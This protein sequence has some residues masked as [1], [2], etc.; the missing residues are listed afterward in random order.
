MLIRTFGVVAACLLSGAALAQDM[1]L[2]V[3]LMGPLG[4]KTSRKGDRVFGRVLDPVA[5]KGDTVEGTVNEVR[6]GGKLRGSAVLHFSFETLQHAG[7]AIP[8][9]T[10]LK[11]FQNSQGQADVDEEGRV[12]RQGGGAA[13]KAAAGTAAGGLIGGLAGGWKGAAIGA[14]AGAAASIAVIE[15]TSDAPEI[16]FNPGSVVTIGAKTRGGPALTALG[17]APAAP[18]AAA[19]AP[20]VPASPAA[21]AGAAPAVAG[22]AAPGAQPDFAMLK[23]DFIPGSKTLL[24]DDFTD[25]APDEAPPHWKVRG[26][27]LTL[28]A[29]GGIRQ[30]TAEQPAEMTPMVT[31]F[32][33]NFTLETEVKHEEYGTSTWRFYTK[34]SDDEALEV[35]TEVRGDTALRIIARTPGEVLTDAEFPVDLQQPVREAIWLQ[36][37]RFRI[38]LN[39]RR[40]VDANQLTLP[41]LERARLEP[42]PSS[43]AGAK[44]S[45]RFVRIAE[46]T[47][48]FGRTILA[49]G[50]YVSYGILFDT[51]SDRLKTESAGALRSIAQGLAANPTLK[52]CI[53]GHTD[54]TGSPAHNLDLSKRRAE[55]VRS[56]LIAQ[57]GIEATRLTA[58]G[59][60]STKPLASNDTPQ[61]RAQ[62]RR[63]EFVK[64]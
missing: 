52:L 29:A 49:S 2:R 33:A 10:Q 16:R 45:Y 51:D 64:Q 41:A 47:P 46:S 50:R 28:M 57:F 36:N 14:G 34:G 60:G 37:G 13:T 4:T 63:V 55:S 19:G 53:E 27:S 24:Y 42:R 31:G 23:D 21:P 25:M 22:V 43:N 35:Y 54:A 61:D 3:E 44:V 17:A 8:I 39:G 15:I 26:A 12:I 59:L 7:Q 40:V 48:D 5:L 6:S 62:N 58:A 38:Y 20:A 11:A 9:D 1:D 32:P 30:V 56:V 18:A